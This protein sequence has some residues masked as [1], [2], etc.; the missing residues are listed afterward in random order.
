MVK[1]DI[2]RLDWETEKPLWQLP[3]EEN[4]EPVLSTPFAYSDRNTDLRTLPLGELISQ[5]MPQQNQIF[6]DCS[7]F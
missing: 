3:K 2:A 4:I 5:T 7:P 1:G 6:Q